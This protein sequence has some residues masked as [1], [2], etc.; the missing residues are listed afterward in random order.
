MWFNQ[1]QKK[2]LN[3]QVTDGIEYLYT[4]SNNL[5]QVRCNRG[6]DETVECYRVLAFFTKYYNKWFVS[7]EDEFS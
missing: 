1:K 2:P 3:K 5:I 4:R 6:S 7:I